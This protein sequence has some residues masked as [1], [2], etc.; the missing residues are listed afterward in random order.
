VPSDV[1]ARWDDGPAGNLGSNFGATIDIFAPADRVLVARWSSPTAV[2]NPEDN[3]TSSG[4]SFATPLAAGVAARF[5]Q[6]YPAENN[7]QIEARLIGLAS[8][9]VDGVNMS[10]LNGSPNRLLYMPSDCK[11]RSTN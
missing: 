7:S 6:L 10:N 9:A 4:T 5:L 2:S 1:D 11:R 3:A 8:T